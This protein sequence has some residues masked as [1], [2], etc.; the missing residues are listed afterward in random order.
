MICRVRR[1]VKYIFCYYCCL[2]SC[3]KSR[4]VNVARLFTAKRQNSIRPV[5]QCRRGIARSRKQGAVSGG[6]QRRESGFYVT[7]NRNIQHANYET[8]QVCTKSDS[9][10]L[11][12][13]SNQKELVVSHS[14]SS[15]A[16][17]LHGSIRHRDRDFPP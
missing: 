12:F 13:T 14:D 5:I 9:F 15:A 17:D 4:A 8:R 3:Y 11:E 16:R 6:R 1:I 10:T 2:F 7:E